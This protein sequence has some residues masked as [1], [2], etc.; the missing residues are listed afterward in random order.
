MFKNYKSKAARGA[1]EVLKVSNLESQKTKERICFWQES[2][3]QKFY[4]EIYF[5]LEILRFEKI[6]WCSNFINHSKYN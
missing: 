3:T 1:M 2:A 4:F 6:A 5:P